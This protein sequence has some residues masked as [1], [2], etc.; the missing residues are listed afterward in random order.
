MSEE[1]DLKDNDQ[2]KNMKETKEAEPVI[3]REDEKETL[4][5]DRYKELNDK[6]IRIHAE[7]DN[8]RKRSN[9]EKL[10]LISTAGESVI[11]DLLPIIDDFERAI[12]NNTKVEDIELVREGFDLIFNKFRGVLES[13]GLKSMDSQGDVFDVDI[14]EA[15]SNIPAPKKKLKGKVIEALEKGYY[16]NDKVIRFAKVVVGQ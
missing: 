6:Y 3:E 8:Y 11:K 12:D 7:F 16:L 2:K 5:E 13:K 9:K 10:D 14:H 4:P 1:K 15:I